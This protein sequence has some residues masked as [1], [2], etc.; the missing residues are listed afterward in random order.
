MRTAATDFAAAI[1]SQH[2]E[3][4]RMG[5][6]ASWRGS[7][8]SACLYSLAMKAITGKFETDIERDGL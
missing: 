3:D 1:V 6:Q 4:I 5:F 2:I 7:R 8:K